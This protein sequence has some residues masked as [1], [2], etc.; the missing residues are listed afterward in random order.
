MLDFMPNFQTEKVTNKDE[1]WID[2]ESICRPKW[3]PRGA[4]NGGQNEQKSN[5]NI[6]MKCEGFQVPLGSVLGPSWAVLEPFWI[7]LQPSWVVLGPSWIPLGVV[8]GHPEASR[9]NLG[10]VVEPSWS[11]L[12]AS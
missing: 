8:L 2:F 3:P 7:V 4:Q 5:I 6:M 12:G 11:R 9:D 1:F 10:V